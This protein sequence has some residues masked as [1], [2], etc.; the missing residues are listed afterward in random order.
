MI[1]ARKTGYPSSLGPVWSCRI[2][3]YLLEIDS[4]SAVRFWRAPRPIKAN[5]LLEDASW[6]S[7]APALEY[8]LDSSNIDGIRDS[9]RRQAETLLD[10]LE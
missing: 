9:Y 1:P 7:D 4:Y 6:A 3:G 8:D 10:R 5:R 2:G